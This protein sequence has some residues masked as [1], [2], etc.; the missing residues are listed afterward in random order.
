L[1]DGGV[2]GKEDDAVLKPTLKKIFEKGTLVL[3]L[4][5]QMGFLKWSI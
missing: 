4:L 5:Q 2:I 1:W 3:V